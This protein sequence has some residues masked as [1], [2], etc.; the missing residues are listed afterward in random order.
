[1]AKAPSFESEHTRRVEMATRTQQPLTVLD[2]L[3]DLRM[4][5][6]RKDGANL[7][8]QAISKQQH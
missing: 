2:E 7:A 4:R 8:L 6:L 5:V 3:D 1:M